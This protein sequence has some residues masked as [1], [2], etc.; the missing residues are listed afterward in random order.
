[1]WRPND[2]TRVRWVIGLRLIPAILV[3]VRPRWTERMKVKWESSEYIAIAY[4]N[5]CS[6][7]FSL[8]MTHYN[9]LV[10]IGRPGLGE[11][12]VNFD[13]GVSKIKSR[14]SDD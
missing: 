13:F 7:I 12:F 14:K 10:L 5:I 11:A 4:R 3:L 2:D 8:L 9:S 6:Y 1:M